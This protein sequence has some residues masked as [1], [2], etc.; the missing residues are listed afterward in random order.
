[1]SRHVRLNDD[2]YQRIEANKHEGESFSETIERLIDNRS[3]RDLQDVFDSEQV[4]EMRDAIKLLE[5]EDAAEV[6]EL[7][8]R[9]D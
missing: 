4:D 9:F 1:M 6:R 8:E 2:L 7:D 3:L 5:E